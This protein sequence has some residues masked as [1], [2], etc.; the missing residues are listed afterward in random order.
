MKIIIERN[1]S[2]VAVVTPAVVVKHDELGN[3]VFSRPVTRTHG[4]GALL[5]MPDDEASR[6]I[7]LGCARKYEAPP[8]RL[9][10]NGPQSAMADA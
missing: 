9:I 2:V 5:E 1:R 8:D 7:A 4:P 3:P 10:E 6:L